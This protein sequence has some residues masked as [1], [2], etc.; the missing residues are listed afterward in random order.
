MEKSFKNEIVI[1][2]A[3]ELSSRIDVRV[4]G[5]TV[6]LNKEQISILFQRDRSVISRHISNIFKEDELQKEMVC[7]FS[8]HTTKH[9]AIKGKSQSKEV[10]YYNLDVIISVGYRVKS[11]QGTQFRIW[12]NSILKDYLL[13]GYS[14]NNR[15]NRIEEDIYSLKQKVGKIDLQISAAQLPKQGVFFENQIF[16]AYH[17]ISDLFRTAKK[18]ILIIDNYVD[19]SVLVHLT[20]VA[21]GVKVKILTKSIS[22]K[23]SLDIKKFSLQ[24]FPIEAEVFTL[25]HDRYIVI[26][27]EK[28]YHVGASLKDLGKK[29]LAFSKIDKADLEIFSRLKDFE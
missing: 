9:G 13:K 12:A 21:K 26:D 28:V 27:H 29:W 2:E 22:E 7:A 23:L 17:V 8:A 4:E 14:I 10:E 20:E 18:S 1:Y 25:A 15:F 5:E 3:Q 6:W 19:D 24:Y 11:K 16:D